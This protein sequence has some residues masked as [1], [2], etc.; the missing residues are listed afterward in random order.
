[1]I[2][3]AV[4][5][6]Q[7]T[8]SMSDDLDDIDH[9]VAAP[10]GAPEGDIV[11]EIPNEQQQDERSQESSDASAAEERQRRQRGDPVPPSQRRSQVQKKMLTILKKVKPAC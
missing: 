7:V 11:A 8:G 9:T 3:T 1:M 4:G 5:N 10:N 2:S 6:L